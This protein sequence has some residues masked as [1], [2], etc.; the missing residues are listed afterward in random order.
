MNDSKKKRKSHIIYNTQ[1]SLTSQTVIGIAMGIS[2]S[3][4]SFGVIAILVLLAQVF[5]FQM[6]FPIYTH[7]VEIVIQILSII[8]ICTIAIYVIMLQLK[9][10]IEEKEVITTVG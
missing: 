3:I 9:L 5:Y 7:F 1:V 8:M 6:P 4:A 2:M 10:T